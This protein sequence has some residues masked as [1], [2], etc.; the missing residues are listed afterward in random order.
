MTSSV[1]TWGCRRCLP[2][3]YRS[4]SLAPAYRIQRR[5]EKI[6]ARAG[7]EDDAGLIYKHRWMR[8][9][10]FNRLMDRANGLD[11]DAD[12]AF[13]LRLFRLGVFGIEAAHKLAMSDPVG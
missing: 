6:Y 5:A 2:L 12:A 9:R 3:R 1:R 13:L 7:T 10:T 4:Q 11:A 8:W